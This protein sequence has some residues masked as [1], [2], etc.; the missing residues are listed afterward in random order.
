[1][2]GARGAWMANFNYV[3]AQTD[4]GPQCMLKSFNLIHHVGII[5]LAA[6]RSWHDFSFPQ[7]FRSRAE[8]KAFTPT[9]NIRYGSE[10]ELSLWS[11]AARNFFLD[12]F[13]SFI[14][15]RIIERRPKWIL[16]LNDTSEMKRREKLFR[17][18][19]QSFMWIKGIL[20]WA[21]HSRPYRHRSHAVSPC[22]GSCKERSGGMEA[23]EK[24]LRKSLRKR[25]IPAIEGA[26]L[27]ILRF[28]RFFV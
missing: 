10:S 23:S 24:I 25:K 8:E 27:R 26:R 20:R 15:A 13:W 4:L 19:A 1:M 3:F 28:V 7:V 12:F 5:P 14:W 17:Q 11:F 21:C 18:S 6:E 9:T 2:K 16:A 22:D